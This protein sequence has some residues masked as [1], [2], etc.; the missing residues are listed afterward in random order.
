MP[1]TDNEFRPYLANLPIQ[2][3]LIQH[4]RDEIAGRAKPILATDSTSSTKRPRWAKPLTEEQKEIRNRKNAFTDAAIEV[5]ARQEKNYTQ[6]LAHFN[7]LGLN[8]LHR[9]LQSLYKAIDQV[10]EYTITADLAAAQEELTKH[11]QNGA[12]DV[13]QLLSDLSNASEKAKTYSG[14][15]KISSRFS[16]NALRQDRERNIR[17][18]KASL[19]ERKVAD[20]Y[21]LYG[22]SS[23][24]PDKAL[25]ASQRLVIFM[26]LMNNHFNQKVIV[27]A[28]NNRIFHIH[29]NGQQALINEAR[30]PKPPQ[31]QSQQV[32]NQL[33]ATHSSHEQAFIQAAT[34]VFA[35]E[36]CN[37]HELVDIILDASVEDMELLDAD[38]AIKICRG[39]MVVYEC[40]TNP[41]IYPIAET[42][43]T[44]IVELEKLHTKAMKI[45]DFENTDAVKNLIGRLEMTHAHYIKFIEEQQNNKA[46]KNSQN[47]DEDSQQDRRALKENILPKTPKQPAEKG[48]KLE[49]DGEENKAPLLT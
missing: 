12:T 16:E 40:M 9:G 43:H 11:R 32:S 6:L 2:D 3:R 8:K 19:G 18:I 45:D 22:T 29:D 10:D 27:N 28:K 38:D 35:K 17:E 47:N 42:L 39:L 23:L 37:Y 1:N 4:R 25:T 49:H 41:T 46:A 14:A 44:A 33:G 15:Y 26:A 13:D 36:D 5:F 48:K 34:N 24:T 21:A 31:S 30:K 20:I 7:S